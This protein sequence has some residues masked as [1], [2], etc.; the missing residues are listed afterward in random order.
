MAVAIAQFTITDLNDITTSNTAPSN[1][2]DGQL[3]LDTSVTPNV[4]KKYN[5]S[6][7]DITGASSIDVIGGVNRALLTDTA[8]TVTGFTGNANYC[9]TLYTVLSKGLVAGKNV[10]ISFDL[11]YT[12]MTK[13]SNGDLWVQ[14]AGDVTGWNPGAWAAGPHIT[15]YIDWVA[16]T[17]SAKVS[18]TFPVNSNYMTNTLWILNLR[19][20]YITGGTITISNFKVEYGDKPTAWNEAPEDVQGEID[21]INASL[22]EMTSDNQLTAE[23]KQL[24]KKDLDAITQ[25]KAQL[26]AQAGTYGITTEKTNYD[27]SYNTLYSY[28]NPLVSDLSSTSPVV[29]TQLRGDFSD[30]FAKRTIL[31]NKIADTAAQIK[32]DAIQIG[33]RNLL[34]NTAYK[35]DLTGTFNR[36]TYHTLTLDITDTYN[37]NNSLKIVASQPSI[38]G[39]QDVWQLCYDAMILNNNIMVS[40]YIKGSVA[41]TGWIRFGSAA[42]AATQHFNI[43]TNWT[44]VTLNL[45]AITATGTKGQVELIYGFAAAGTYYMNSMMLEYGTKCSEWSPAPEDTQSQIDGINASIAEMSNDNLLTAEEK[46]IVKKDLDICTNEKTQ[47]DATAS[48]YGITTEKNNYDT[49]YN[50]LYGYVNPLVSD[51]TKTS[52]VVGTQLRG[53]FSDYFSKRAILQNK[54]SDTVAQIKADA[55]KLG[56]TNLVR[57]SNGFFGKTYWSSNITAVDTDLVYGT[58]FRINNT[59]TAEICGTQT[60]EIDVLPNTQYTL[61]CMA[62]ADANLSSFEIYA[63]GRRSTDNA[64]VYTYVHGSG[65]KTLSTSYTKIAFTFTTSVDEVK[66]FVR[67]DHNGSKTAGTLAQL[68]ATDFK[69]EQGNKASDWSP[70]PEDAQQQID[71]LNDFVNNTYPL[72]QQAVYDAIDNATDQLSGASGGYVVIRQDA[73]KKPYE[74]LIMNTQD[75]ATATQ[76]WRWNSGGLGYSSNGYNGPYTTAI[77][78]DGKIVADFITAGSLDA[79]VIKGGILKLGGSDNGSG[80]QLIQDAYG[81][82]IGSWDKDGL[83]IYKYGITIYPYYSDDTDYDPSGTRIFADQYGEW[84]ATYKYT[85]DG[86]TF[87]SFVYMSGGSIYQVTKNLTTG[88]TLS[89][90]ILTSDSLLV[91]NVQGYTNPSQFYIGG[92]DQCRIDTTNGV[93]RLYTSALGSADYGIKINANGEVDFVNNNSS[94]AYING[95]GVAA[96]KHLRTIYGTGIGVNITENTVDSCT[97]RLWLNYYS[98]SYVMIGNGAG[99]GGYGSLD[100]GNFTAHGSKNRAVDT[101]NYGTRLMN[102]FE[103]PECLFADRGRG[104]IVNGQCIINVDPIFLETVNTKD[105]S[106]DVI[107][108]PYG[109]GK[110]WALTSEMYS[111]KFI[112][113]GDTDIEFGYMIIAKQK[114]YE[115]IR[116]EQYVNNDPELVV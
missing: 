6:S 98:G 55:I 28:V 35:K 66:L 115:N 10:T 73:N 12:G 101:E 53:D 74:I 76:V 19:C 72:N 54:I 16:G 17:G 2:T 86:S 104:K 103:T 61:S 70:A 109:P 37:N 97:S 49:S 47:F 27:N 112:V 91:D 69:L 58:A 52:P 88:A 43:T 21:D 77:T 63:I 81:K 42:I 51:L 13:N 111:D 110:V 14:G 65:Q 114:D 116:L 39:L 113:R 92:G 67:F 41:T 33:S 95:S 36:G 107:T 7:W 48:A 78:A 108:F 11:S 8:K 89:S 59:A 15:S 3:W 75:I 26:D 40:F 90:S 105:F 44:K 79:S 102:A 64:F 94:Y 83:N 57:N 60:V 30:Y 71:G 29:G 87:Q 24:V 5:G 82:Q 100:C 45:G 34:E 23:E 25:E 4:L 22:T 1:P 84:V 46:Q 20:D 62:K 56:I 96:A 80:S 31:Q 9:T 93:L 32:T 50:T 106:Y 18:L 85:N 99:N 38:D 68:W